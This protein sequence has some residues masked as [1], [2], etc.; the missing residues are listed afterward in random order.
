[1]GLLPAWQLY[2]R[3]VYRELVHALGAE[4]VLIL[5]AGWGLLSADFLTPNYDITFSTTAERYKRRR[6][7][8]RYRDFCML[9][10]DRIEPV[11]FLGGKDYVPLRNLSTT[12]RHRRLRFTEQS[13]LLWMWMWQ[14]G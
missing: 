12:L 14:V 7:R 9:S 2:D 10:G 11:V 4:N 1:M 6:V 3:P 5:S 8:D 13:L